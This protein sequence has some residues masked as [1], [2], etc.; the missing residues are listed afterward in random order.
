MINLHGKQDISGSIESSY[1]YNPVMSDSL[2]WMGC[3][4]DNSKLSYMW[5]ICGIVAEHWTMTCMFFFSL[6][7][8]VYPRLLH[9]TLDENGN[10]FAWENIIQ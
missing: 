9:P 1:N 3:M 10:S 2:S 5:G 7:K 8:T 6:R 4:D